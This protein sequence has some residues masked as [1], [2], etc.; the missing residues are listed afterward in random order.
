[1]VSDSPNAATNTSVLVVGASQAGAQLVSSLRELGHTGPVTMVGAEAYPPYQRPPLSKSFLLDDVDTSS[2][3]FRNEEFYD[4]NNITVVTSE[5]I[6][7]VSKESDGYGI[8]RAASGRTFPFDR[9]ALTVGARPRRLEIEGCDL[10]GIVYLRDAEHAIALKAEILR[11]RH[12]LVVGGGLIGLEVAASAR[13]LGCAVTVVLADE[14]VLKRSVGEQVSD[15]Y[16]RAHAARG[17]DIHTSVLPTRF[18]GDETRRV[19]AVELH[20]GR[21][22]PADLVVVGIGTQPRVELALSLGLDVDNG[23]VVD[24]FG[25]TSDGVTVA[26]GDCVNCPNPLSD[27]YGN[28]RLRFESVNAAVEQARTAAATLAGRREPYRSVP[29]YWSNQFDL[30]LQTAGL[31]AGHDDFVVRG[32]PAAEKFSVLYYRGG[33]LIAVDCVNRP[34]DFVTVRSALSSGKT[35]PAAA[36]ADSAVPLKTLVVEADRPG[37]PSVAVLS[38]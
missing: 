7:S 38:A 16:R 9:L 26:A 35:I 32:D 4:N 11:A 34:A 31:S 1:M 10:T 37:L 12:V 8:A 25:V 15:F 36:A 24:R 29:W 21:V 20:D 27:L 6:I 22:F 23:I 17:V 33:R 30:K 13:R 14:R 5:R 2:L 19:R 28:H 18:V 3:M